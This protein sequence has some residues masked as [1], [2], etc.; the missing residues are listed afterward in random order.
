L[1]DFGCD[2]LAVFWR[3]AAVGHR[4]RK[5]CRDRVV[6][7]ERL[8]YYNR[9]A[10]CPMSM[11]PSRKKLCRSCRIRSRRCLLWLL[12]LFKT[13]VARN[14]VAVRWVAFPS[15]VVASS[16]NCYIVRSPEIIREFLLPTQGSPGLEGET[17]QIT[18]A[19]VSIRPRSRRRLQA[20]CISCHLL[21]SAGPLRPC[22]QT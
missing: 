12:Q 22:H 18:A 21:V 16:L 8:D 7:T 17:S 19:Q 4:R 9:N 15:T 13:V 20:P 11:R 2:A 5:Y 14:G 10:S 1:R 3:F 6:D